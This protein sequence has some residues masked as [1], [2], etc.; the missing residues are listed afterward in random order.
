[1]PPR[2]SVLVTCEHSPRKGD[3]VAD[4]ATGKSWRADVVKDMTAHFEQKPTRKYEIQ[5]PETA[6]APTMCATVLESFRLT[7]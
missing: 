2:F 3:V 7:E 6:A 5:G 4:S 1:M